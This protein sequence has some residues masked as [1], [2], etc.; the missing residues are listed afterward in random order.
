MKKISK[1][2]FLVF[3]ISTIV[4]CVYSD[5][6]QS[7]S[8]TP[9]FHLNYTETISV[10]QTNIINVTEMS[11]LTSM[12]TV[13]SNNTREILVDLLSNNGG[14]E[15]PCLLGLQNKAD[16]ES[17]IESYLDYFNNGAFTKKSSDLQVD[18]DKDLGIIGV[19]ISIS[20]ERTASIIL[21]S[22]WDN[23]TDKKLLHIETFSNNNHEL[24]LEEKEGEGIDLVSYY[25]LK[26][27]LK[28]YG[29]PT[30]VLLAP[31]PI[32][33]G[34]PKPFRPFSL[35][36]YYEN[37]HF[38]IQYVSEGQEINGNYT[39]CLPTTYLDVFTWSP[40][41]PLSI[42]DATSNLSG[43]G[44]NG[45]DFSYFKKIDEATPYSIPEFYKL[46][47]NSDYNC[48]ETPKSLWRE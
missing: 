46:F 37:H 35:V 11:T 20:N 3:W 48:L 38:V 43:I 26:N 1:V 44:I 47:G 8:S 7:V 24:D 45:I 27:I 30:Q 32:D 33:P 23:Q 25:S 19:N 9:T 12:P 42:T 4:G 14:C 21:M 28:T 34:Y 18:V 31:I 2:L 13:T 22:K 6:M 41:H 16:N 29:A 15:L 39:G 17:A 40:Q 10:S 36:L 5:S